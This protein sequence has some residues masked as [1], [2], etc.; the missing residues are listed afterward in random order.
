MLG[1]SYDEFQKQLVE[2]LPDLLKIDYCKEVKSLGYVFIDVIDLLGEDIEDL[3]QLDFF[4]FDQTILNDIFEGLNNLE[5]LEVVAPITIS[6]LLSSDAVKGAIEESGFTL[7]DLGLT[8]DIDYVAELMNLPNIYEKVVEVGLQKVEGQIDFSNV[9]YTK[10]EGLVEALF[11]SVIIK[12][13]VPVVATT[14]TK[15]YLPDEYKGFLP[16]ESLKN[17]DWEKEFGPVLTAVT[18]LMKTGIL[19]AEEPIQAL[20]EL[21]DN[22]VNELGKYLAKSDLLCDNMNSLLDTLLKSFDFE[23]VTFVGLDETQGEV[24]DEVEISSLFKAIKQLAVGLD[25]ELTDL[26]T[27]NLAINL[28]SSKYIKKNLTN[29]VNSLTR[30]LGFELANLSVEEIILIDLNTV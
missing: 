23:G 18:L 10:V 13:A 15:T 17:V 20:L 30:D 27:E 3:S 2:K 21:D 14:L 25:R 9:D 4:N 7:E 11:T 12:N 1:D 5:L 8:E 28:S 26:E 16:E 6:Y 19:N 24:W 22:V 29:L